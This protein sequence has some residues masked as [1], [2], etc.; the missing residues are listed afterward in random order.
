MRADVRDS[1]GAS[2][3]NLSAQLTGLPLNLTFPSGRLIFPSRTHP[4]LSAL[5]ASFPSPPVLSVWTRAVGL[6][7]VLSCLPACLSQSLQPC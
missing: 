7:S 5:V 2:E 3:K 6:A 4:A 1:L